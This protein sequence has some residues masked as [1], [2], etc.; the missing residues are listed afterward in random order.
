MCSYRLSVQPVRLIRV[1]IRLIN[2]YYHR[3][4]PLD[5]TRDYSSEPVPER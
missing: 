4:R 3:L 2:Y 1:L 5:F